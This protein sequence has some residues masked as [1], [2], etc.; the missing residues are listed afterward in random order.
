MGGKRAAMDAALLAPRPYGRG[1]FLVGIGFVRRN[2]LL[3]ILQCQQQLFWIELLRPPAGNCARR[4]CW[5]RRWCR[6][7]FC[8][9]AWSRLAIA[10]VPPQTGMQGF[11]I[12]VKLRCDLAHAPLNLIRLPLIG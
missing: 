8:K 9:I 10:H 4:N 7:S 6:R 2:G 11:D 1:V 12:G 3:E 5:R